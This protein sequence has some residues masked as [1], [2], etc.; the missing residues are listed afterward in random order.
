MKAGSR[1]TI[2]HFI[3]IIL[4]CNNMGFDFYNQF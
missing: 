3:I 4:G 1:K 2:I